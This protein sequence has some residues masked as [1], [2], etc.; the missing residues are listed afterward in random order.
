MASLA[1][2]GGKF[3]YDER[4][5]NKTGVLRVECKRRV[6]AEVFVE[7]DGR[8]GEA[9]EQAEWDKSAEQR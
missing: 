1:R 2:C 6:A 8:R 7:V 5:K 9:G 3:E 4:K